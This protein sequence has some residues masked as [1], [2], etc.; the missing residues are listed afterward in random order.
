MVSWCF[1]PSPPWIFPL[2]W[3]E[4]VYGNDIETLIRCIESRRDIQRLVVVLH[5][6]EQTFGERFCSRA[7][8]NDVP[9]GQDLLCLLT[10]NAAFLGPPE[11][12]VAPRH[13]SGAG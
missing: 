10:G 6:H 8:L 1:S 4:P 13:A 11:G 7:L 12:M 3:V 9:L 2:A 5:T